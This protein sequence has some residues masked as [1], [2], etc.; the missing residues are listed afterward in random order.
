MGLVGGGPERPLQ[1]LELFH[2]GRWHVLDPLLVREVLQPLRSFSLALNM[3]L[4]DGF[5]ERDFL[6]EL[7]DVRQ[8]LLPLPFGRLNRLIC[9]RNLVLL[10]FDLPEQGAGIWPTG[11]SEPLLRLRLEPGGSLH[12]PRPSP[13]CLE[14]VQALSGHSEL[15][16]DC[17]PRDLRDLPSP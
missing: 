13:R 7:G 5:A 17:R 4:L 15:P 9:L 11:H 1:F 12:C 14:V 10:G 16:L 2:P 8:L 6:G 3:S